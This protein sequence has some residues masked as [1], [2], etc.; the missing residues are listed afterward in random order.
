LLTEKIGPPLISPRGP[1]P[2]LLCPTMELDL[3]MDPKSGPG[4]P[5]SDEPLFL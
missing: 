3:A 5:G 4:G 1:G 2:L